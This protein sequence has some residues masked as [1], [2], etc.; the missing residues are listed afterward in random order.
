MAR[1]VTICGSLTYP[2]LL[3]A[4]AADLSG[5]GVTIH[6]PE[7]DRWPDADTARREYFALIA[8]SDLVA[9]VRKPDGSL[10]TAAT[11]ELEHAMKLGKPVRWFS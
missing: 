8:V 3:H 4:A 10:G 2:S 5:P 9:V 7:P 1:I 6:A 11:E